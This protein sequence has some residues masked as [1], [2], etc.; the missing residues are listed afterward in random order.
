MKQI[1]LGILQYVQ[2]Y[3][4]VFPRL[5]MYDSPTR[6]RWWEDMI[7]PYT[8]NWQLI[9]CPSADPS[10]YTF[11]RPAEGPDPLLYGYC[12]NSMTTG[13][14]TSATG[15]YGAGGPIRNTLV[16]LSQLEMPS[17][18]IL[19]VDG[20][21]TELTQAQRSDCWDTTTGYVRLRHNDMANWAFCDGHVKSMKRSQPAMWSISGTNP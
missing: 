6:R 12:A 19:L 18:T 1:S 11:A 15:G 7:Y 20:A 16:K 13:D 10:S 17:Q 3:D 9:I 8:N 2:D 5:Y 14:G 4:E 21:G